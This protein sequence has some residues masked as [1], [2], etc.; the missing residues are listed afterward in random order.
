MLAQGATM[1]VDR[2]DR[3]TPKTAKL[4]R[5]MALAAVAMGQALW[6]LMGRI[7]ARPVQATKA[8][9]TSAYQYKGRTIL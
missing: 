8:L 4:R 6:E 2:E 5:S 9:S 7:P 3:G 1:A